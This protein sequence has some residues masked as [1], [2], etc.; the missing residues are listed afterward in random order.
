M[1]RIRIHLAYDGGPFHGWQVQPGL[2]TI[3]GILEEIVSGMEGK[4]VHVHV[5]SEALAQGVA[6]LQPLTMAADLVDLG[7]ASSWSVENVAR[8][9]HQV[10][11]AFG[12]DRLRGAADFDDLG[13]HE[14]FEGAG[15]C[16]VEWADRVAAS[17]PAEYLR[18]H[19]SHTGESSRRAVIEGVGER[20]A[21]IVGA[22]R[23]LL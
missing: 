3:Q 8:L 13:A 4:H 5:A 12:F 2:P 7:N 17:L 20:Y 6:A 10:G 15:V 14:Y 11:A 22:L 23:G 21:A 1:R 16:V 9:Y 19:L 18:V